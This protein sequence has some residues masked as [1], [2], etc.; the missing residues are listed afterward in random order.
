MCGKIGFSGIGKKG[1]LAAAKA[2]SE[3]KLQDNRTALLDLC[4]LLVSRMMEVCN[5]SFAS[6]GLH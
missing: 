2:L 3:E 1:V 5:A 4:E 6:V